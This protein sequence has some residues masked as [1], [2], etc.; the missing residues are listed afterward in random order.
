MMLRGPVPRACVA[1]SGTT[2]RVQS[3]DGGLLTDVDPPVTRGVDPKSV[4]GK[5]PR[6]ERRVPLVVV[7]AG[8]AGV[9]AAIAAAKAGVDVVLL[10]ENPVD[11]DMMA[12]DVPLCFGQRLHPALRNRALMLARVVEAN[13]ALVE[14]HD[15]GVDVQLGTYVWGA[16][17]NGPTVRELRGPMLGLADQERSWLL[18][19]DRLVVAAGARDLG[20]A[21]AG[22]EQAGTMGANGAF[23]LMTR[24]RALASQR[25]VVLGSG[26]LGLGTAALALEHGLEVAG[27]VEVSPEVRGDAA[28]RRALEDKGVRFYTAH[29]VQ[30]ARGRTGEVESVVLVRLDGDLMPIA[31]GETEIACDSICLGIGLVPNVELL[32]LLGCRLSFR[33]ELG[34]FV[35]DT[36]EWMRTSVP[37]VFVAGDCAGFHEGMLADVDIARDQGRLAGMAVAESL[38]AIDPGRAQALRAELRRVSGS[39]PREVHSHWQRWLR[40]LINTGG[41]DV[42]IC[43]CEEVTR[44][45][46][47]EVQPPRYLGWHSEAM[48]ARTLS[49]LLLDGPVHPDQIK[50]LTRVGMGPCQGRRCREQVALLLAAEAR[51]PVSGIPLASYRPPV[52]PLPLGVLWAHDE[53]QE[54][55]DAWVTWFGI[56]TQ[57]GPHWKGVPAAGE[58][59]APARGEPPLQADK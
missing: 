58:P 54:V 1:G 20:M 29:T 37:T 28:L 18:G 13:P 6:V 42:Y 16:F 53:P 15:A 27:V 51:T 32:N 46:L 48:R 40:S 8:P 44:R 14:A 43:Q 30:Q 38:G 52:R 4:A 45:E 23:S 56:P 2:P 24:Y 9:A 59:T 34:G 35:P 12:M 41:W 47:A 10:D 21:F 31:G 50:R 57:F 49:T 3:A 19:Y 22:W 17:P 7:G 25:M 55:R 39:A 36:D 5:A 11:H 33:S 26:T